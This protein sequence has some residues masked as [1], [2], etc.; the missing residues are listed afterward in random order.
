MKATGEVM[1][2]CTSFEGGLMKA[3]R[4]LAQHVDCLETGDYDNMSHLQPSVAF[5][6]F[7][8]GVEV[9]KNGIGIALF[10][11]REQNIGTNVEGV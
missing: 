7:Q 5:A 10:A 11:I 3:L 2:I 6:V 9:G 8:N 1:S 4:S